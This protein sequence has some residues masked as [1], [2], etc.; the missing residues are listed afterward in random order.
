MYSAPPKESTRK[1]TRE[2]NSEAVDTEE[3]E[4]EDD[5]WVDEQITPGTDTNWTGAIPADD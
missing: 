4:S 3:V 2:E 1:D 5:R